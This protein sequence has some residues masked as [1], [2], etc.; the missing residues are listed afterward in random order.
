M[1]ANMEVITTLLTMNMAI[2]CLPLLFIMEALPTPH[3]AAST[4]KN[5]TGPAMALMSLKNKF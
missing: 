5:I 4:V 1:T 3:T 2:M